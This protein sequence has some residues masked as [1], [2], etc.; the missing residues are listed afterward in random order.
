MNSVLLWQRKPTG[1]LVATVRV[2][3]AEIKKSLSHSVLV[4]SHLEYCV[5]FWFP[6]YKKDVARLER[7]QRWS[8]KLIKGLGSLPCEERL[9]DLGL[10]SLEKR[11]LR[12]DLTTMIHYLKGGYKEDEDSI[13]TRSHMEKTR[14]NGF[15]VL[16][17]R[18]WLDT[19]GN[20]FIISTISHW[21]NLPREVVD[22]RTLD[23]FKIQRDRVLGHV[24]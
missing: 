13:F 7:A 6:L 9:G 1:C 12:G 8:T 23:T 5:Q 14:C 16:L 11:V 21:N 22:L 17:G 3:P 18:F 20:F 19:R 2:S 24:V 4:R 15:K 10:F